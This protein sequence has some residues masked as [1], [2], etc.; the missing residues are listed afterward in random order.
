MESLC[1]TAVALPDAGHG[2]EE[3]SSFVPGCILASARLIGQLLGV[4][5][6]E[7]GIGPFSPVYVSDTL[8]LDFDETDQP[9]QVG[10]C[11]FRVSPDQFDAILGRIRAAGIGYRSTPTG[12]TDMQVN[13]PMWPAANRS[14]VRSR[15]TS[16]HATR[17]DL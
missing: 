5:W 4:P 6:S 9:F 13:D 17:L 2:F 10:H 7:S 1:G 12:P 8:T 15:A 14:F 3:A 16:A 11:A